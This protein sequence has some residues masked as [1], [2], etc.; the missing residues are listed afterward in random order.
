[1]QVLL[2]ILGLAI[3]LI[4]L[5]RGADEMVKCAIH[6]AQK[7]KIP[8][9]IVGAVYIGFGTS[10]PEWVA[11]TT[12][13]LQ[14]D[15]PLAIG[16]IIGSNIANSLLVLSILFLLIGQGI[17]KNL[18]LN[19]VSSNWMLIVT[20]I[21]IAGY[22]IL[23]N[24]SRLLGVILLATMFFAI[25]SMTAR[26][27]SSKDSSIEQVKVKNLALRSALSITA[28]IYGSKLV[29]DSAIDLATIYNISSLVIGVVVVAFGTSLPEIVST[30]SAAK[31]DK[32]EIVFGNIFGSNLFNIG[33]VGGTSILIAPGKL[34]SEITI[35][36]L[37][38]AAASVFV[39]YISRQ[40][41]K[42]SYAMGIILFLLYLIFILSLF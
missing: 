34:N 18:N 25:R 4:L 2:V 35:Q 11:S 24:F 13:V 8:Q 33:L 1:M 28:T 41:I 31:F 12:A 5:V 3:G 15:L 23:N 29:V 36:L 6:I 38:M 10:A 42:K 40:E 30:I 37:A 32:P 16:N 9:S 26:G 7:Y 27:D 22:L 39:V 21:F 19:L 20:G 17:N 14:G